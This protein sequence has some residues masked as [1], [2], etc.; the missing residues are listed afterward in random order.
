MR[1]LLR[2]LRIAVTVILLLGA[3]GGLVLYIAGR[4]AD[5]GHNE[6]VVE[7]DRPVAQVF[8][9]LVDPQHLKSW[10]GWQEV[11]PVDDRGPRVGARMRI[12]TRVRNRRLELSGEITV[13]EPNQRVALLIRSDDPSWAFMERRVVRVEERTG[14]SRVRVATDATYFSCVL[15]L[16]EPLITMTAQR[17][18]EAAVAR[19]KAQAEAQPASAPAETQPAIA[20]PEPQPA[21]APTTAQPA[22]PPD[23]GPTT[24][25]PGQAQPAASAQR[26]AAPGPAR[27]A[28][29]PGKARPGRRRR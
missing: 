6:A 5:A 18:L 19:L 12:I 27:R 11:T 14:R 28:T 17:R 10:L 24:A 8:G 21:S 7:I 9:H 13:L 15:G 26:A 29:S 3:S 4:R 23:A 16:G 20:P 22:P 25:P 1:R 2:T